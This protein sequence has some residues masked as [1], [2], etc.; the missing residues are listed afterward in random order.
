[1]TTQKS[2]KFNFIMNFILTL[3]NLIFPIITFP[4]VSRILQADGTGR[5]SF[6]TSIVAY[7]TM[8]GM[9]GIP[10]YGI[11]QCSKVRENKK[12]LSKNVK[13]IFVINTVAMIVATVLYIIAILLVPRLAEDRILFFINIITLVFNLLGMEWVYRAL[14]KYQYITLRSILFKLISLILMFLL[15]KDSND[16]VI[17]GV[18]TIVASVGSNV[19][20]FINIRKY[21][22]FK[23]EDKLDYIKHIKPIMSFF[24]LTVATTVYTNLDV[25]MLGFIKDNIEVG[26]Y[27]AAVKIKSI[28]VSLV[29]SLGTVLLPRLSYY[30][31]QNNVKEFERLTKKAL[32][33]IWLSSIPLCIYFTIKASDSI[34]F[35]SGTGFD[36]AVIPMQVVMPTLVFIGISNLIGIQIFVPMDKERYVVESVVVGAIVNMVINS[37]LIPQYGATGAAIGTV[38]AEFFVAI[39]QWLKIREFMQQVVDI[40]TV[41]KIIFAVVISSI[42]II[43]LPLYNNTFIN[44]VLSSIAFFIIYILMLIVLKETAVLEFIQKI[45]RRKNV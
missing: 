40:K 2:V 18:I 17:Y 16:V 36:G 37:L 5:I 33:F 20:N 3:S 43:I 12:E 31:A 34:L 15:I 23:V 44:L 1:M 32:D 7:F 30:V 42:V 28:L 29:T 6:V 38:V 25:V 27:N 19:L 21:V 8:F 4:Y 10:N 26:Y 24:V 39:Y 14:E 11:R 9:L 41:A 45:W 35:L 13:E 22:D